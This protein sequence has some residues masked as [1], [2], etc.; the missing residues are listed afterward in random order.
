M[1]EIKEAIMKIPP[2]SRYYIGLVFTLS[3]VTTYR[4][5][6]P[7]SLLLDFD[8]AIY[9]LQVNNSLSMTRVNN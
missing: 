1:E 5:V 2:V 4:I 9:S 3:F 7:Y 8:K 6:S